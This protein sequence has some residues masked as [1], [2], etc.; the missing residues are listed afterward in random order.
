MG[1]LPRSH[2]NNL[3]YHQAGSQDEELSRASL[4]QTGPSPAGDRQVRQPEPEGGSPDPRGI[5]YQTENCG[6]LSTV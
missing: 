2:R 5:L 6:L 1:Q 3:R 4:L